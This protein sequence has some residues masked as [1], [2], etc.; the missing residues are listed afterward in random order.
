MGA[1]SPAQ[2]RG[3]R[4]LRSQLDSLTLFL[5]HELCGNRESGLRPDTRTAGPFDM[6]DL[7]NEFK[8]PERKDASR[9][10]VGL[11][12]AGSICGCHRI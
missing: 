6:L 7:Q 12:G 11:A 2:A 10:V 4:P 5:V 8:L 3:R 9:W 1:R